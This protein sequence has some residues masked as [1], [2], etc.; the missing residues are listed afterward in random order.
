MRAG[1]I[2]ARIGL[3]P[4]VFPAT[5]A[6]GFSRYGSRSS[7]EER[8]NGIKEMEVQVLPVFNC[9]IPKAVVQRKNNRLQNDGCGFES[10]PSSPFRT[11]KP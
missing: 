1:P 5:V 8:F 7:K 3:T 10:R 6:W 11:Q 4:A 2:P 9:D